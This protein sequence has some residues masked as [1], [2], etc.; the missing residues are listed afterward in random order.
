MQNVSLVD[1]DLTNAVLTDSDL[2]HSDC[3]RTDFSGANLLGADL[4]NTNLY[5]AHFNRK[6]MNLKRQSILQAQ[7]ETWRAWC[8]AHDCSASGESERLDQAVAVYLELK[9]NFR[10]IGAYS[11][12]SWA[13]I[14]ER[15]MRC[16]QHK[17][18][19]AG[20]CF[21]FEYPIGRRARVGFYVRHSL[22]W[23]SDAFVYL[24][25]GY[26]E[27]LGRTGLTFLIFALVIFPFLYR[28]TGGVSV[29]NTNTVVKDY[30]HLLSFSIGN[31]FQGYPGYEA[32]GEA[33][34][35]IQILQQFFSVIMIGLL[36]FILGKKINQ[37]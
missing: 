3:S 10:S 19:V 13:Y 31:L 33:G 12:A 2:S 28:L 14:Q 23:F 15:R 4:T 34:K 1:C 5:Q 21:K 24:T 29:T 30:F 7:S 26:G 11:E 6:R 25:T 36:G 20:Q 32:V 27:S 37:S 18:S 9:D 17:I 22:I 35:Q 16:A 8:L